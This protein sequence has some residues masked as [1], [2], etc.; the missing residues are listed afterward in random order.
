MVSLLP[1]DIADDLPVEEVSTGN[2]ILII[3]VKD[4]AATGRANGNVNLL[5]NF[6]SNNDCIGPYLFTRQTV[7]SNA[8]VHTR[9]LAAHMGIPEDAATGSAAGPLTAYLLKYNLFGNK[10]EIENEQGLEMG[11]PSK[12]LMHG[13]I[14]GDRY[15]IKTGG[16]CAYAGKGEFII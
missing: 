10:F 6:F 3:P 13:E 16:T 5:R 1:E 8:V 14:E 15:V 9:F 7:S 12:I 11:R 2:R 4:L